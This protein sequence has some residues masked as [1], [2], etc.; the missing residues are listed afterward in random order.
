MTKAGR[1]QAA[2][3]VMWGSLIVFGIAAVALAKLNDPLAVGFVLIAVMA[4]CLIATLITVIYRQ[5]RQTGS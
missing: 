4:G 1:R 2:I 3:I 5:R